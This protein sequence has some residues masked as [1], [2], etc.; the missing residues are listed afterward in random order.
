MFIKYLR[1]IARHFA[2][3]FK[4]ASWIWKTDPETNSTL[5][6]TVMNQRYCSLQMAFP[7]KP[8]VQ[9]FNLLTIHNQILGRFCGSWVDRK[10]SPV[11]EINCDIVSNKASTI[12]SSNIFL[13]IVYLRVSRCGNMYK[14]A[15]AEQ[16]RLCKS[17]EITLI[18][19]EKRPAII[20]PI[21][22]LFPL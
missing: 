8:S 2:P 17:P 4:T 14:S 9:N 19:S 1:S 18:L 10:S 11:Y 22:P 16:F 5:F 20:F 6:E 12:R 15:I 7:C 13:T 21:S 3:L